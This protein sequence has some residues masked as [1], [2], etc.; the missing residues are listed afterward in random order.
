ME[1]ISVDIQSPH[2][3]I[4]DL[5]AFFIA[6]VVQPSL[7]IEA[8]FR[9]RIS[10]KVDDGD[11]VEERPAAPIFGNEAEHAVLDL[12]PLARARRKVRDMDGQVEIIG[13]PL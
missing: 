6:F 4:A 1:W 2:F 11:A 5:A 7:D 8:G 12:I 10:D 3:L 9:F 13:Q